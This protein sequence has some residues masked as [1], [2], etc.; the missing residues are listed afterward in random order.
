MA[1]L[2]VLRKN[3][4]LR[5]SQ[6]EE[7]FSISPAHTPHG[8]LFLSASSFVF[9]TFVMNDSMCLQES[10]F[11]IVRKT[12]LSGVPSMFTTSNMDRR[13]S[14]PLNAG[15]EGVLCI[16]CSEDKLSLF[17]YFKAMKVESEEILT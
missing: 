1:F 11:W 6:W 2:Q 12:M 14:F 9:I 15:E 4:G 3:S 17:S 16:V 13:S 5:A 10:T 7:R 8:I